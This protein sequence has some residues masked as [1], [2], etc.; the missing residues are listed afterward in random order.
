MISRT[1]PVFAAAAA[2]GLVL[3]LVLLPGGSAPR[4]AGAAL[5]PDAVLQQACLDDGAVGAGHAGLAGDCALLLA[6]KDPLR[7]TATLNW[8]AA[9]AIADWEGITVGGTPPRVTRLF[10]DYNSPQDFGR[11]IRLTGTI[12]A[13]LGG[14]VAL[15]WL[16]LSPPRSDG[17]HPTGAGAAHQPGRPATLRQ[18]ADRA[19][20]AG[21]ELPHEPDPVGAADQPADGAHPGGTGQSDQPARPGPAK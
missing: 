10:I 2:L 14:L 17:R 1:A 20:P 15:E 19:H 21:A 12:P 16:T 9:T 4:P 18:R 6:A 3:A 8:S 11:R 5:T 13:P 7:G